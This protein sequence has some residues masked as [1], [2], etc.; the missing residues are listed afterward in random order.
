M[1]AASR[2]HE[3]AALSEAVQRLKAYAEKDIAILPAKRT[4][5]VDYSVL[6]LGMPA[7]DD[8]PSARS[9]D[10]LGGNIVSEEGME[11]LDRNMRLFNQVLPVMVSGLTIRLR[12]TGTKLMGDGRTVVRFEPVSVR[13]GVEMPLRDES[14]GVIR[15][16]GILAYLIRAFNDP[17]ACV[18]VDGLDEGMFEYLFGGMLEEFTKGARG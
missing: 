9:L 13:D 4:A 8:G 1:K 17:D 3:V 6:P 10:L 18:A 15:I 16:I 12:R 14:E 11:W 7:D 5:C 2:V